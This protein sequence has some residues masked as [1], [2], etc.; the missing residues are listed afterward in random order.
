MHFQ[1]MANLRS[2]DL[3]VASSC[4]IKKRDSKVPAPYFT[5]SARSPCQRV[6]VSDRNFAGFLRM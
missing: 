6:N 2:G 5:A 1:E 4:P 3:I